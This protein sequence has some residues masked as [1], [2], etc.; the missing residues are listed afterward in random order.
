MKEIKS[1]TAVN[2]HMISET[3]LLMIWRKSEWS[4]KSNQPPHSLNQSLIQS[5]ALTVF[6][7]MK[8]ERSKEAVKEKLEAS[9][10]WVMKFKERN[11]LCNI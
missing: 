4:R 1:A 10:G 8:A 11:C 9:R 3:A 2:T 5:K 6:N 7:S